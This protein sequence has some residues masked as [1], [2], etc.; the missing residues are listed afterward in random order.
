MTA[1]SAEA[2]TLAST[3]S[4]A[5]DVVPSPAS[6]N[7][8]AGAAIDVDVLDV[9]VV[10]VDV[11][12]V[13]T[14]STNTVALALEP[15]PSVIWYPNESTPEAPGS[16]VYVMPLPARPIDPCVGGVT[17]VMNNPPCPPESLTS[18]S[19]TINSPGAGAAR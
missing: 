2:T 18:T 8:L 19:T 10:V 12:A 9:V 1:T 14:M 3:L 7:G 5:H 4:P 17:S 15:P 6:G 11:V 16:A 13:P